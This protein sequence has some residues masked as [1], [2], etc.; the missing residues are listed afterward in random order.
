MFEN[1]LWTRSGYY[2]G[3][4]L[5]SL[6]L[7]PTEEERRRKIHDHIVNHAEDWIRYLSRW[8]LI[9]EMSPE[10]NQQ[11]SHLLDL[12]REVFLQLLGWLLLEPKR[13]WPA[14]GP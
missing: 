3:E 4:F 9:R 6:Q 5:A 11:Y 7:L 8:N 14:W 13:L 12:F 2:H 1:P 10:M